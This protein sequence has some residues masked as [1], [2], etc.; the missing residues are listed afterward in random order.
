[1]RKRVVDFF[2]Q[3]YIEPEPGRR[4][5]TRLHDRFPTLDQEDY[6]QLPKPFT[7]TEIWATVASMGPFKAPRPDGFQGLF[8]QCYWDLV[9]KNVC[10]MVMKVLQGQMLLDTLNTTCLALILKI[11]NP[12]LPSQFR[13]ISLS[14]V[15]C[16]IITK[17][18]VQL[19]LIHI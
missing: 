8:Y 1:M 19:S 7:T 17:T 18:I 3:L 16:K 11:D 2:A 15:A 10:D 12:Q 4:C 5:S 9:G 13:P 6:R 14:N